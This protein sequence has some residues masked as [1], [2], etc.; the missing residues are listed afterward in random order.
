MK[1]NSKQAAA[2][3]VVHLAAK[4][5]GVQF[6]FDSIPFGAHCHFRESWDGVE[7]LRRDAPTATNVSG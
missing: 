7:Y 5:V 6:K 4:A 2:L 3:R 1:S